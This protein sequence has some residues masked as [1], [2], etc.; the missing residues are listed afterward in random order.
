MPIW[1]RTFVV[2]R[3]LLGKAGRLRSRVSG[4]NIFILLSFRNITLF[5]FTS[6]AAGLICSTW[7]SFVAGAGTLYLYHM[8]CCCKD[9]SS[10]S[11]LIAQSCLTLHDTMDCRLLWILSYLNS[12]CCHM[13]QQEEKMRY[14]I[15]KQYCSINLVFVL[16]SQQIGSV[17]LFLATLSIPK[18]LSRSQNSDSTVWIGVY[19]F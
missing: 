15:T 5:V 17:L 6:L 12:Q 14:I 2:F 7:D 8:V 19:F 3:W 9:L 16:T 11:C 1:G 4:Y 13:S 18:N 10:L